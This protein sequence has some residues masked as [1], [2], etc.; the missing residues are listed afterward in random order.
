MKVTLRN[1][2]TWNTVVV[3]PVAH[4]YNADFVIEMGLEEVM[5]ILKIQT[6]MEQLQQ[7]LK[8]IFDTCEEAHKAAEEAKKV[9]EEA[10]KEEEA[11]L[12]EAEV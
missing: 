1:A 10:A 12:S 2:Y 3:D 5:K 6:E 4:N 11:R 9:A 7:R 8:P